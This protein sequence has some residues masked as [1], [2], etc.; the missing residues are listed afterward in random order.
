MSKDIYDKH[1]ADI[2]KSK[3]KTPAQRK[4]IQLSR[5]LERIKAGEW[6]EVSKAGLLIAMGKDDHK[7]EAWAEFGRRYELLKPT[8]PPTYQPAALVV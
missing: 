4:K 5:D 2:F 8:N 7:A 6:S 3:A 1:T